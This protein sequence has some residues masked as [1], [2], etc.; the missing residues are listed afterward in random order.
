MAISRW[1]RPRRYP[2][3]HRECKVLAF[4]LVKTGAHRYR[5]RDDNPKD[6][7]HNCC[8]TH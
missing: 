2:C 7:A 8:G 5:N 6:V 1:D 4:T 3:A